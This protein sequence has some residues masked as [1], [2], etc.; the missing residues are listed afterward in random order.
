MNFVSA[1]FMTQGREDLGGC[2]ARF[3]LIKSTSKSKLG[4]FL[5]KETCIY[6]NIVFFRRSF[7]LE[8]RFME[9]DS[10]NEQVF[11]TEK[12]CKGKKFEK[13]QPTGLNVV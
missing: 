9:S 8:R 11:N 1:R 7:I 2:Y 5:T 4:K 6:N 13:L 12:P 10:L 3:V